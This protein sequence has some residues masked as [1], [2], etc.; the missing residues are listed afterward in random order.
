MSIINEPLT[1]LFL[2][3]IDN[4]DDSER[5]LTLA[6]MGLRLVRSDIVHESEPPDVT[7]PAAKQKKK[8]KA[9]KRIT[10]TTEQKLA[11]VCPLCDAQPGERCFLMKKGRS[12][13]RM[14]PPAPLMPSPGNPTKEFHSVRRQAAREALS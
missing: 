10:T 4:A 2:G 14:E 7:A 3:L 13:E 12:G 11:V 8:K 1:K 9:D 5:V 6:A